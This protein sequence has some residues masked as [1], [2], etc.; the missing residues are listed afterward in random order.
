VDNH[1]LVRRGLAALVNAEDDMASCGEV[2]CSEEG[3]YS[4][5]INTNPQVL[6]IVENAPV[7]VEHDRPDYLLVIGLTILTSLIF[8][9][10]AAVVLEKEKML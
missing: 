3:E 6:V 10:L 4:I 5:L 9:L 7:P 1:E 8:A 2:P